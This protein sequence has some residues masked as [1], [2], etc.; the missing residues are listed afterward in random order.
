MIRR[1]SDMGKKTAYWH[2]DLLYS[3]EKSVL[4]KIYRCGLN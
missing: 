4:A 2:W 3:A 1:N